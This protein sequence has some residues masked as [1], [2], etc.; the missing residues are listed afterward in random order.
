L[1]AKSALTADDELTARPVRPGDRRKHRRTIVLVAI[2]V[3]EL[4]RLN[5]ADELGRPFISK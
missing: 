5:L 4:T 2:V 1:R 3:S